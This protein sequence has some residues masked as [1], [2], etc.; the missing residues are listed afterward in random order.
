MPENTATNPAAPRD[1]SDRFDPSSI[2]RPDDKLLTYYL[3]VAAMT[4]VGFPFVFI[5]LMCKFKT[6]RYKFDDKGVSMSWGVLFKREIY[7][8]YRRI[9]DIHVTRNLFHRW[10]GLADVAVQT[11]SGSSGAE[12]TIEGVRDPELLRN[13]LYSQMRG[14]SDE[15]KDSAAAASRESEPTGAF[16]SSDEALEL[17]R[18]IRDLIRARGGTGAGVT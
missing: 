1:P 18:E 3:M 7:L 12:M 6:L 16:D 9:Q 13:F 4:I 2:K 8:T 11:A 17:L 14:V 15:R 10:L 5:P